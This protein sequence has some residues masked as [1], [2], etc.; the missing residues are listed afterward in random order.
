MNKENYE[1]PMSNEECDISS[2]MPDHK[3]KVELTLKELRAIYFYIYQDEIDRDE[4]DEWIS[5]IV[6]KLGEIYQNALNDCKKELEKY[7]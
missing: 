2:M 3:V 4:P 6:N 1:F 5:S 7:R